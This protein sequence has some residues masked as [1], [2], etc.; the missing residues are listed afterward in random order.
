I[1]VSHMFVFYFGILANLTPPVALAAFAGAGIAGGNPNKTGI[2]AMKLALAGF[3]VPYM[4]VYSPALLLIGTSGLGAVLVAVSALVGV[5]A[6]GAGVE[7]WLVTEATALQRVLLLGSAL[8]LINPGGATDV[9]GLGLIA[10]VYV[11]QKMAATKKAA[12]QLQL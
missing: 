12:L 3:I 10:A 8:L 7:G 1:F 9:F 11:W 5:L 6:L 2:Q 4:F